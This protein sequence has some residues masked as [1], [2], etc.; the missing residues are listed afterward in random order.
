MST[1]SVPFTREQV[2][3]LYVAERL[4]MQQVCEMLRIGYV[5]LRQSMDR[6]GI[7]RRRCKGTYLLPDREILEQMYVTQKWTL[8]RMRRE[9]RMGDERLKR[10]LSEA[11]I[12]LRES[13]K[14]PNSGRRSGVKRVLFEP[15]IAAAIFRRAVDDI[16]GKNQLEQEL[17]WEF[18]NCEGARGLAARMSLDVAQFEA[19]VAAVGLEG[20][21]TR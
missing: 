12:P 2:E 10:L 14:R 4:T 3:R 18:L 20:G 17:A 21:L 1:R 7:E 11:G 9:L 13:S 15:G 5:R 6:W 16:Q 19:L 8:T